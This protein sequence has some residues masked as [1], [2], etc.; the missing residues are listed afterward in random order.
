MLYT[1][2]AICSWYRQCPRVCNDAWQRSDL[3]DWISLCRKMN[4]THLN[5]VE[6]F[7]TKQ[8]LSTY[9]D[10]NILLAPSNTPCIPALHNFCSLLLFPYPSPLQC[11]IHFGVKMNGQQHLQKTASTWEPPIQGYNNW[12][13][14]V[15]KSNIHLDNE[16]LPWKSETERQLNYRKINIHGPS[17]NR[18]FWGF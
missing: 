2:L 12:N 16:T 1:N 9:N 14:H 5:D 13:I 15:T 7:T 10:N 11:N 6:T 18:G 4:R 17:D 8:R 3:S